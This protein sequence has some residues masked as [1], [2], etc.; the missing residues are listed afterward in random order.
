MLVH[1]SCQSR[2]VPPT[3]TAS[4]EDLPFEYPQYHAYLSGKA[5]LDGYHVAHDQHVERQ[6]SLAQGVSTTSSARPEERRGLLEA[7]R[8]GKT[9]SRKG[10]GSHRG[11]SSEVVWEDSWT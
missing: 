11:L 1:L 3:G 4:N 6:L 9:P 8:H 2:P 5:A 10:P 7:R